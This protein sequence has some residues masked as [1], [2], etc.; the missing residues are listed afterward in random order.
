MDFCILG[1]GIAG[2]T[3]A[4]LLSKKYTVEVFDKAR[5]PGGR[6]STKRFKLNLG[7]D[8]GAQ[9]ISPKTKKFKKFISNLTQKKILKTWNGSHLDFFLNIKNDDIKY[10]GKI[11]NNDICKY[12]L[13]NIKQN[14]FSNITKIE[15]KKDYWLVSLN[16]DK[17]Y[18]F[19]RLILTCPFPQLKK[20]GRKYLSKKLLGLNVKMEPNITV[21]LALKNLRN[22]PISSAKF[23][24]NILAWA[25][26][27]NSKKRFTSKINL[28][29]LQSSSMWANK[30]INKYKKRKVYYTNNVINRFFSL[31]G[32]KANKIEYRD[33]H[34]WK[35]SYNKKP[36][37]LK[38]YWDKNYQLGVCGDWFLGPKVEHAWISA[39]DLFK[40][41]SKK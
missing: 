40:K 27:E 1:S 15:Y 2:S 22:L 35:Y 25:S 37:S 20:I 33:I 9:Y 21:M 3:I 32:L 38:S 7:F 17:K 19:K 30:V 39:N 16:D 10:I 34:G 12:Q 29:T 41:I 5:G 8:H 36:T 6:T 31:T 14:Y 18:K 4:N 13:K 23:K 11:A 26:N 28:W 24:D